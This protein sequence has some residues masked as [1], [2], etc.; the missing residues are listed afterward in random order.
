M[1]LQFRSLTVSSPLT[2]TPSP[3]PPSHTLVASPPSLP[4]SLVR[5]QAVYAIADKFGFQ[6]FNPGGGNGSGSSNS[7][8]WSTATAGLAA[9]QLVALL[10]DA[11]GR[12]AAALS[13]QPQYQQLQ[14]RDASAAALADWEA[15]I[16]DVHAEYEEEYQRWR[17]KLCL[18]V[19]VRVSCH[20]THNVLDA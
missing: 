4:P 16:C 8:S 3:P 19:G 6:Q 5:T 12:R 14:Q 15:A 20:A 17:R 9:D 7:S 13:Q 18:P 1:L 2:P 11:A 10:R